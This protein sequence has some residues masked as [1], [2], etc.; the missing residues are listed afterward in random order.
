MTKWRDLP[1]W[2]FAGAYLGSDRHGDWI[3]LPVGTHYAR[4][5]VAFDSPT[6]AVTLVPAADLE[7]RGWLAAFH[8]T[9]GYRYP[10]AASAV[11]VYVDI[12]TP[13]RWHD[14]LVTSVDLDLD[15]LRGPSGR[16]WIDDEDEFAHHRISLD[17]PDVV[18]AHAGLNC[19]HVHRMMRDRVAPF[20]GR[21][22]LPWLE[23]VG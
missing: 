10:G 23:Q 6:P 8:P 3:G 20:D 18:V 4:P 7:E 17:Y 9:G 16:V 2:E 11:E 14:R 5:G 22:H 1:H 19:D 13:P 15:V 21:T 12:A